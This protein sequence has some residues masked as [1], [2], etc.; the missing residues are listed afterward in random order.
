MIDRLTHNPPIEYQVSYWRLRDFRIY[1]NL[2]SAN[3][4]VKIK[5]MFSTISKHFQLEISR[6]FY[7]IEDYP[8]SCEKIK[9]IE[10]QMK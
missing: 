6:S 1:G 10:E 4:V 9:E 7:L 8:K 5:K 3:K 2:I